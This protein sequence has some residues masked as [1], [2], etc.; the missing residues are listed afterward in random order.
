MN[1]CHDASISQSDEKMPKTDSF[2]N[3]FM[4]IDVSTM[5]KGTKE[6]R[7]SDDAC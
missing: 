1:L 7:M 5:V 3:L 6:V 4:S 2:F